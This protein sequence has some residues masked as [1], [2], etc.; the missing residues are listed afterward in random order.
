MNIFES[1]DG[2]IADLHEA[3]N[4][5]KLA[6]N[7][8][9]DDELLKTL[10]DQKSPE[11]V[12]NIKNHFVGEGKD[13]A[14]SFVD[15][16]YKSAVLDHELRSFKR[17][18]Y[19]A[20]SLTGAGFEPMLDE[21][22]NIKNET[23]VDFLGS[24]NTL[25]YFTDQY[26]KKSTM[27]AAEQYATEITTKKS[28]INLLK[29][30]KSQIYTTDESEV[31]TINELLNRRFVNTEEAQSTIKNELV[32]LI[33]QDPAMI[34]LENTD[35]IRDFMHQTSNELSEV[36]SK[37]ECT[38]NENIVITNRLQGFHDY[39]GG[40]E[41]KEMDIYRGYL[42]AIDKS[43]EKNYPSRFNDFSKLDA[44]VKSE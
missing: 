31:Q 18:E 10:E 8:P 28:P 7:S 21:N 12:E 39:L 42:I 37:G 26:I 23:L 13:G 5:S 15:L 33:S 34:K 22:G 1:L 30:E 19:S 35:R 16:F 44:F 24:V 40:D 11:L 14:A 4:Q 38:G 3:V 25:Q 32:H 27:S 36:I 29:N 43:V 2:D 6:E 20:E 9:K 41:L 17:G